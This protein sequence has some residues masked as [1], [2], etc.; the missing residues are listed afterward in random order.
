MEIT[1]PDFTNMNPIPSR[2]TC[3]GEDLSPELNWTN[4]PTDTRIFALSCI[5]PDAP[6]GEFIH[7]LIH[8]I[9]ANIRQLAQGAS[10]PGFEVLNDFGYKH[11]GGPCPPSGTHRYFFT[12][13]ALRTTAIG[14]LTKENFVAEVQK[15]ALASAV[16]MGTYQRV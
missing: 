2:F 9:P 10:P 16:I 12:L 15:H 5:D 14:P 13:Y 11:Y 3:D 4:P 8:D 1:S 7:W 6:R